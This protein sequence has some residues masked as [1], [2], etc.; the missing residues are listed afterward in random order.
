[1]AQD[2]D[3]TLRRPCT[4]RCN[5]D[6]RGP[7]GGDQGLPKRGIL[8]ARRDAH[9][10][11]GRRLYRPVLRPGRE[12]AG[13]SQRGRGGRRYRRDGESAL[14][15]LQGQA[16]GE[17]AH[18]RP[19]LHH[20]DPAA[21]GLS[22]PEHDA[23]AHHV[24]CAAAIR[25]RRALGTRQRR[26]YYLYAYRLAASVRRGIG[27]RTGVHRRPLRERVLS[28]VAAP[29]QDQGRRAGR[30]RGDPP[31]RCQ[32][33]AGACPQRPDAG[34]IPALPADLGPLH[35]QPDGQRRL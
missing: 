24:H 5:K 2:Q 1:M 31:H 32:S 22:P 25:G 16:W 7:R 17:A 19:S 3:R 18:A 9:P 12:K 26:P 20:L 6:G 34:A 11:D 23:A 21:G 30:P 27:L 35:G 4:V 8:A 33:H 14:S 13:A 28:R 10:R 15:R 29:L